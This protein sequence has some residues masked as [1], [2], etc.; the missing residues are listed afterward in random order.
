MNNSAINGFIILLSFYVLCG[1]SV[2]AQVSIN[3]AHVNSPVS[4]TNSFYTQND[5]LILTDHYEVV[6]SF[7]HTF[8]KWG[9]SSII[10]IRNEE[11][12]SE[13]LNSIIAKHD[14]DGIV[15]L[16]IS[17]NNP[18]FINGMMWFTKTVALTAAL[19]SIP[20]TIIEPKRGY[21]LTAA[22]SSVVYLFT[23]AA[24][25]I[26]IEGKVVRLLD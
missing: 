1:C 21:A 8:T 4:Q 25:E 3:A 26:K 2:G 12:I 11:D 9:V 15:D 14:G 13:K 10:N 23:P 6:E 5:K 17:V 19:I 18:P 16:T 22:G 7:S 24:A 20:A